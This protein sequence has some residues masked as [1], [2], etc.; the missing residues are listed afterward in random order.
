MKK[1][2]TTMSAVAA[3]MSLF[4]ANDDGALS[5]TSF[6]GLDV[7]AYNITSNGN[8]VATKGGELVPVSGGATYWV[9]NSTATLEIVGAE[10]SVAT[11][12][13]AFDS[14]VTQERYLS[15]LS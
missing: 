7:G 5:G 10:S 14:G 1:L 15:S 9:T 6:E 8:D 13:L 3:A 2:L 11:R 4:A 12:P